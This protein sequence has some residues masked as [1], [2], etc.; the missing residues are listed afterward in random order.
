MAAD[1]HRDQSESGLR[2]P[3]GH[4]V[5]WLESRPMY[6]L[7][8]TQVG[9]VHHWMAAPSNGRKI[10]FAQLGGKD[11]GFILYDVTD[12][13]LTHREYASLYKLEAADTNL[14]PP[15]TVKNSNTST[16]GGQVN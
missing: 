7:Y 9:Q 8:Q 13:T 2:L 1:K 15:G 16:F 11:F 3:D 5:P 14:G 6:G 12:C 10:Q 4:L